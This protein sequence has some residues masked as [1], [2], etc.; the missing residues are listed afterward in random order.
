[1]VIKMGRSVSRPQHATT[2]CYRNISDF[3]Y[4]RENDT[5]DAEFC[6]AQAEADWENFEEWIIESVKEKFPS[7][8]ICNKWIGSED[9][10]I[11]ENSFAYIGISEYC[12]LASIWL[13]SKNHTGN[14]NT[15]YLEDLKISNLAD[16]FCDR[17]SSTFYKMFSE[18]EKLGSFSNGEGVYR[19]IS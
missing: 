5:D 11:L 10:A 17:I 19:K 1:M 4:Y 14:Y 15:Y 18:Y 8:S 3:G 13:I 9:H 12:G 16:A 7:F 6:D 2:T